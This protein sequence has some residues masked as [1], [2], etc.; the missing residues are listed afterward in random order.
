MLRRGRISQTKKLIGRIEEH[1]PSD[2]PI[3][4]GGDFNEAGDL[5]SEELARSHGVL[6]VFHGQERMFAKSFPAWAPLLRLDRVYVRGFMV[7]KAECLRGDPWRRLSDH[8][9][10]LV[11]LEYAGG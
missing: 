6:D 1:V 4:I 10:L 2:H 8:A 11:E 3:I 5:V 9:P 7:V